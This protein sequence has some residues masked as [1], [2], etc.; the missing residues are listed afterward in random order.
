MAWKGLGQAPTG[1]AVS[2]PGLR[3]LGRLLFAITVAQG[4]Q[5]RHQIGLIPS[6]QA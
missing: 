5:K 2:S 4:I 3:S 1:A 6:T